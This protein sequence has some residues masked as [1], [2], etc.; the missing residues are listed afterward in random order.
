VKLIDDRLKKYADQGYKGYLV[1]LQDTFGNPA[2]SFACQSWRNKNNPHMTVLYDPFPSQAT[3][4]GPKETSMVINEAGVIVY[5]THGDTAGVIEQ[6][7]VD[8]LAVTP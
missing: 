3:L 8:E 7:V 5:K 2:T 1:I 6:A 4:Y